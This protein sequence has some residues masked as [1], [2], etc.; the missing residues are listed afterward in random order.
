VIF[1]DLRAWQQA[2]RL[3]NSIYSLTRSGEL[4]KDF[5]LCGQMQ[6]ASVSI[7]SNIAEGFE[8][9]HL[10][11]KIQFYNVA[12]G[13]TGEVRSLLYVVEDNFSEISVEAKRLRRETNQVGK[14]ITG[15]LGSTLGR[16]GRAQRLL[17]TL[18]NPVSY[19]LSSNFF[20]LR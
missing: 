20:H 15:L 4:A 2:R 1:E 19:L 9:T 8:R 14:L 11:E 17:L 18:L 3:V 10:Q 12:R 13:S 5:R 7:M 6:S 16:R